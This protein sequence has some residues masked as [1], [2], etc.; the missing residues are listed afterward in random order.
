MVQMCK[1]TIIYPTVLDP[2]TFRKEV[3]KGGILDNHVISAISLL[4]KIG[5]ILGMFC[6]PPPLSLI[7]CYWFV[8]VPIYFEFFLC[9]TQRL[10]VWLSTN[11]MWVFLLKLFQLYSSVNTSQDLE[12]FF[13]VVLLWRW[14][15][16]LGFCSVVVALS[17]LKLCFSSKK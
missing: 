15:S 8:K 4:Y 17:D 5:G 6:Y 3:L 12:E 13:C 11:F 1:A 2:N 14:I 9:Q 16:F 7:W 10:N